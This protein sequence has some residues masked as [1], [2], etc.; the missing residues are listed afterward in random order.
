M[1]ISVHPEDSNAPAA[2]KEACQAASDILGA[3]S[4]ATKKHR[5]HITANSNT[6]YTGEDI[7]E[8][9]EKNDQEWEME[10]FERV[11][12]KV[13]RD[14]KREAQQQR[15]QARKEVQ[16]AKRAK[17]EADK[18]TRAIRAQ[19]NKCSVCN[20][21]YRKGQE[22]WRGCDTCDIYWVCGKCQDGI[23]LLLEHE[24]ACGAV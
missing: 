21:K 23:E 5:L 24:E 11:C 18:A 1:A 12:S 9:A 2:L 14:L 15:Q 13:E 20:A 16:E 3:K 8:I 4:V 19:Q 6:P 7:L 17:Q 22:A 10:E